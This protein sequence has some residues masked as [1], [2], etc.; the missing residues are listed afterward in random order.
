MKKKETD[1][2]TGRRPHRQ[3]RTDRWS[4]GWT[5]RQTDEVADWRRDGRMDGRT[6]K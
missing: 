5:D 6:E 3:I 2:L 4:D 1:A